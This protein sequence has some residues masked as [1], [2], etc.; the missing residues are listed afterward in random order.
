MSYIGHFSRDI[1]RLQQENPSSS[2][3]NMFS[4]CF[5]EDGGFM[6]LGGIDESS[7]TSPLCYTRFS[8]LDKYYRV[9][10]NN[11][12]FGSERAYLQL[13]NWNK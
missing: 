12:Q 8:S 9:Q 2:I 13:N 5:I 11:V 4:F 7:N 10:V 6:T 3:H 1:P